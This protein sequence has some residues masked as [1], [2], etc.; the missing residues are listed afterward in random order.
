[1]LIDDEKKYLMNTYSRYPLAIITG[2]GCHIYDSN[3]KWYLDMLGGIACCP[4]GHQHPAVKNAIITQANKLTN[5]SN[6]FY[7]EE[8][9]NLAKKLVDISGLK[10]CFFSNSGTEANEAAIKLAMANTK[11]HEF[12]VCE[13]A[14]HGRTLGSLS[15]THG[16]K[17]T[18]K[19]SP[20]LSKFDFVPYGDISAITKAITEKT[21]AVMLEPIQEEAGVIVPPI[22]YLKELN[23]ICQSKGVLLILDEVQTGNGRTGTYF[24]YISHNI[25]P[26]IVTTAKGLANG[27]PIGATISNGLD[28]EPGD[29][30]STFGGNSFVSAV[31]LSVT[32]TIT[33]NGMMENAKTQGSYI[34]NKISELGKSQVK[35]IRGKGLM[36]GIELSK[37]TKDIVAKFIGNGIIVNVAHDN[38]IRLLPPLIL[39]T[40]QS[41]QFITAFNEVVL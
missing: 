20:L 4:L 16:K 31:A 14:F 2:L 18:Q 10:K 26:D 40:K 12:I 17:Y 8:Q 15:A 6:L 33:K 37:P 21:A 19:F 34:M 3:G 25:K 39:T 36:V 41:D 29:H 35:E 9:I 5:I 28:F 23:E 1:M 27:L 7:T 38:T 11:K 24:E 22:D 30:A 13:N 32:D